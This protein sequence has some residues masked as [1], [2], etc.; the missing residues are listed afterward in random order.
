MYIHIAIYVYMYAGPLSLDSTRDFSL[1]LLCPSL[2]LSLV[3]SAKP[4][5]TRAPSSVSALLYCMY[6]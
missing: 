5:V 6:V 3:C 4:G 2:L 1:P